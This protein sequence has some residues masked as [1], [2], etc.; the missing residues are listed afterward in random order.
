MTEKE[1]WTIL[2][3]IPGWY[4]TTD[5]KIRRKARVHGARRKVCPVC[6]VVNK[7]LRSN[8]Y[9]IRAWKAGYDIG[10]DKDFVSKVA[11][12]ADGKQGYM[13]KKLLQLCK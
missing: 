7:I 2:S 6:A 10:L 13:R 3:D 12:A 1:F 9:S 5:G 8:Q 11:L 4:K